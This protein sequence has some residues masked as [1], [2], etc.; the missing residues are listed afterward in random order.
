MQPQ[1]GSG[2]ALQQLVELQAELAAERKEAR[3]AAARAVKLE[4]E[5]EAARAGSRLPSGVDPEDA[6]CMK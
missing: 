5:L 2:N 3:A 4:V 1:L 6:K